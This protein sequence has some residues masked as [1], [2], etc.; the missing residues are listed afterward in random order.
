MT[1]VKRV[2]CSHNRNALSQPSSTSHTV[3]RE[4]NCKNENER[5]LERKCMEKEIVLKAEITAKDNG[6]YIRL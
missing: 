5:P 3:E 6:E 4:C 1:N 2:I